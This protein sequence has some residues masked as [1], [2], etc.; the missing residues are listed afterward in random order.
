M[1]RALAFEAERQY[2]VWQETGQRLGMVPKQ[3]RGWDDMAQTTKPQRSKE[4]SS[5]YRYFP[6]PDLVPVCVSADEV[7]QVED[8]LGELPAA[9]RDRLQ[10]ELGLTAYDADVLVNQGR[11]LTDYFLAVA[12]A[13]GDP[14]QASNWVQRD[15][16]RAL[17]E[18]SIVIEQFPI[19]AAHLGALIRGVQENKFD[20]S[21]A[22]D[23]FAHMMESGQ[24]VE[25]AA[26]SLGIESVDREA[27]VQ[28]CRSL[29]EANPRIVA[30]VQAGKQQAVGALIGQ[31]KRQNPNV[32]P[33]QV[34]Q[35][36]LQLIEAS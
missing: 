6:D 16:I 14:R 3:T 31:A 5:D 32:N 36:C 22:R 26:Q 28:L 35:I 11:S 25:Q 20:N 15:V 13:S 7:R 19:P 9:L 27:I 8:S 18:R 1:E 4:E 30:D 34:R 29:L 24:T 12:E 10:Q 21:R 23:L 17:K 33:A 2:A